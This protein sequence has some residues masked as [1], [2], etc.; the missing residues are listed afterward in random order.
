MKKHRSRQNLIKSSAFGSKAMKQKFSF[1]LTAQTYY[2]TCCGSD[3]HLFIRPIGVGLLRTL[4]SHS[5]EIVGISLLFLS[6]GTAI[7]SAHLSRWPFN[8]MSFMFRYFHRLS[9]KLNRTK[10]KSTGRS[11]LNKSRQVSPELSAPEQILQKGFSVFSNTVNMGAGPHRL[12]SKEK[13]S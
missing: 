3:L 12:S 5:N 8:N 2:R 9:T 10:L 11:Q 6:F 7:E 1:E 4:L 13:T